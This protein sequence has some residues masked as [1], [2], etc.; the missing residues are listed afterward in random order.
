ME[1]GLSWKV[2]SRIWDGV[3]TEWERRL[4]KDPEMTKCE[5]NKAKTELK[6]NLAASPQ[7]GDVRHECESRRLV[8]PRQTRRLHPITPTAFT[9]NV[10]HSLWCTQ[11]YLYTFSN[12]EKLRRSAG[13]ASNEQK[14]AGFVLTDAA[15]PKLAEIY[16][17][18]RKASDTYTLF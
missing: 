13:M 14:E 2:Q 10:S 18:V 17:E 4:E 8:C 5:I 12:P 15:D 11:L 7:R 1:L 3:I 6:K 16:S 9:G